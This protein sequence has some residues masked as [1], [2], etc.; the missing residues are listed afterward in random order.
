MIILS[1]DISTKTGWSLF[2]FDKKFELQE[3]GLMSCKQEGTKFDVFD[4]DSIDKILLTVDDYSTKL[5]D[6]LNKTKPDR[7]VIEQTNLG[8]QRIVQKLL[9]WIHYKTIIIIK[10]KVGQHPIFVDSSQW[11]KAVGLKLSVEDRKHNKD[12]KKNKKRG[13]IGK[14]QLAVR[15][16]NDLFKH[17]LKEPLKMKDNDIADSILVGLGYYNLFLGE[18]DG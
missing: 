16:V 12:I 10:E 15:I 14:K 17:V 18:K 6:L 11:R 3:Y 9:E 1:L 2:S 8:R 5:T 13:K 4:P 7:V